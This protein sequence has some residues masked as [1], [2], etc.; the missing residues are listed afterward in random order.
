MQYIRDI[1]KMVLSMIQPDPLPGSY[2]HDTA[3][4]QEIVDHALRETEMVAENHFDGIIVQNMN[5][6]PIRQESRPEAIAYM[7]RISY[8]IKKRQLPYPIYEGCPFSQALHARALS[9]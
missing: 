7:T 3:G 1:E 8:E 5:D 2:R 6:M 4:I 9:T